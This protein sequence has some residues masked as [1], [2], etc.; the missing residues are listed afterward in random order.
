MAEDTSYPLAGQGIYIKQGSTEMV[1]GST[2]SVNV[3][4]TITINSSGVLNIDSGGS[5]TVDSGGFITIGSSAYIADTVTTPSSG[6]TV[7]NHGHATLTGGTTGTGQKT[8]TLAQPVAGCYFTAHC[9][10]A[11]TTDSA[12]LDLNGAT[13]SGYGTQ[14]MIRFTT[15][16]TFVQLRG[17]STS[18]WAI[19]A[20]TP[21]TTVDGVAP[22]IA[23]TS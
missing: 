10:T 8:Y 17:L 19:I 23:T 15:G 1:I 2:A 9:T 12:L 3:T 16:A 4:G 13:L 20:I 5:M 21:G 7:P 14:D 6:A 11:N 18:A 22:N